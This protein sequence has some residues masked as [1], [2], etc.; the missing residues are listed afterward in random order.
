[1][2]QFSDIQNFIHKE[3]YVFVGICL[4][5]TFI[6]GTFSAQLLLVG[7]LVTIAC[8]LFFRNPDR[9]TPT[10][11]NIIVAPAD[12]VVSS[13]SQTP[14]PSELNMGDA[15]MTKISIFLS[16]L[17]V[18]VNRIPIDG[19][20][21]NLNYNPGKF[22]NASLDKASVH[23]ERQSV[24]LETPKGDKIVFVQIAGLIARRIVC[25]LEEGQEVKAG[26]RYGIIRFGSR[27]DVYM[28]IEANVLVAKGQT[29]IG[30]ET[31]IANLD[32]DKKLFPQFELR[33]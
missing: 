16:V 18:H 23:N 9:M 22:F 19:K 32:Y 15:P 4:I 2:K 3:G 29:T 30:G 20:V 17:D 14:P 31:I 25:D 11:T 33:S 7:A 26:Q 1:M 6:A 21:I 12:G 13:I 28:P 24:I 5:L 10:E 8:A 27:M